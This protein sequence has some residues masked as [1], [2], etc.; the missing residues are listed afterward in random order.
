MKYY[1]LMLW[2]AYFDEGYGFTSYLKYLIA[3]I[4]IGDAIINK[5]LLLILLLGL[6]YGISC[7][8][9]GAFIFKS[10]MKNAMHEVQNNV[11]PFV[12]EMRKVYK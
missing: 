8:F 3:I 7:F 9:I 10:G 6:G 2:K 5:N 1:R 12:R 11:N 4:G